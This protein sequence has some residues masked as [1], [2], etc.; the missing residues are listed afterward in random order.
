MRIQFDDVR[1]KVEQERKFVHAWA[2]L[3]PFSFGLVML[4][5]GVAI[6]AVFL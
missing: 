4:V 5:V 6:G 1:G 3:N 2:T